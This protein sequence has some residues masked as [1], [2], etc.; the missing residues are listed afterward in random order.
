MSRILVVDDEE[1]VLALL[2]RLLTLHGHSVETAADGG[3]AVDLLLKKSYDLMIID[4]FMP[5][6]S[7]VEAVAVLRT[8]PRFKNL[9][10]LMVTQDSLGK[11][12]E[13]AFEAGVNGYVVKPFNMEQLLTKVAK[14]LA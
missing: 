10:I 1:P 9:K 3:L 12:V 7:G 14:A 13:Q 11:D 8:S 2:K 4:R 5:R 6:M